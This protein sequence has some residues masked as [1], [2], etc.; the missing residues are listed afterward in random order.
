MGIVKH[1]MLFTQIILACLPTAVLSNTEP[2]EVEIVAFGYTK[3]VGHVSL[4]VV[5]PAYQ[6]AV[7]ELQTKY[8]GT[9]NFTLTFVNDQGTAN[10]VS[11]TQNGDDMLS[12]WY[13]GQDRSKKV[14]AVVVGGKQVNQ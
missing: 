10:C 1:A 12:K 3:P 8:N 7:E 4:A 5:G 14:S 9:F 6:L 2:I 13:Y 11:M